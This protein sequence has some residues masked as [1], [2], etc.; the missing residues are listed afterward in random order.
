DAAA[1]HA[2]ALCRDG[3]RDPLGALDHAQ[4][5]VYLDP[6]FAIAR[7]HLGL[8]ARKAGDLAT[9]RRELAEARALLPDEDDVRL[10]LFGGGFGRD[11]LVALCTAELARCGGAA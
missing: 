2:L 10:L 5:A 1:H 6:S 8:R 3:R 7:L 9:A 4:T 11:G